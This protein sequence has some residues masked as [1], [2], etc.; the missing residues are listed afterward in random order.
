[1][2]EFMYEL[3]K[4]RMPGPEMSCLRPLSDD[5]ENVMP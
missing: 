5:A 2:S 4:T 3:P 1:M